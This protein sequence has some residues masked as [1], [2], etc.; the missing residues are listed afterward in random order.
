MRSVLKPGETCWNL[1]HRCERNADKWDLSDRRA[2]FELSVFFRADRDVGNVC[3][4]PDVVGSKVCN[5]TRATS[6]F[7]Q[8]VERQDRFHTYASEDPWFEYS[9]SDP[10]VFKCGTASIVTVLNGKTSEGIWSVFLAN[11]GEILPEQ[12]SQVSQ[13]AAS[14]AC[15]AFLFWLSVWSYS[16][17]LPPIKNQRVFARDAKHRFIANDSDEVGYREVLDAAPLLALHRRFFSLIVQS[18]FVKVDLYRL[19][20][21]NI[22]R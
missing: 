21:Q 11:I 13:F 15:I 9:I 10:A 22:M 4:E 14:G 5:L 19:R 2:C 20:D 1:A 3:I 12:L 8:R 17:R 16:L 6:G 18:D 7:D